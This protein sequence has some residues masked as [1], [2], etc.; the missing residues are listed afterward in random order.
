MRSARLI[1]TCRERAAKLFGCQP[2][3]VV[4]T[5]SC[6]YGLNA[7]IR[8]LVSPGDTV[9]VSGFEHNAVTRALHAQKARLSVCGQRLFA[10]EDTLKDLT[11]ALKNGAKIAVFTH[12]S[13]VF[14]YILPLQEIGA[15]CREYGAKLIVDAAQSAG[16]LPLDMCSLG[17]D[18]IAMPG[19]KGLLG[20]QGTGVLLCAGEVEPLVMGGT[21]SESKVQTMPEYLPERMEAG[22]MNVPGIAGLLAGI[23]LVSQKGVDNILRWEQKLAKLCGDALRGMGMEVFAGENQ[24]GTVSFRPGWDCEELA[25]SLSGMGIAVRAGL[26]CAPLAH[27]SAGTLDTGTVRI[28]FGHASQPHDLNGFL[29]AMEHIL[30]QKKNRS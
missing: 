1:Y 3:Q 6:T 23:E 11:I 22:T 8:T 13:N 19:H 2:E 27:K 26:H 24:S 25:Q 14:G 20:P 30:W 15:L 9:A 17:A 7:A 12:V 16:M 5:P 29:T 18:F 10:P 21:G 28:S 4:F